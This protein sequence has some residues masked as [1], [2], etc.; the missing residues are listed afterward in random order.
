MVARITVLAAAFLLVWAGT[1]AARVTPS[2][3]ED[4]VVPP[5]VRESSPP[6]RLG[7]PAR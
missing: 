6:S 1:A 7:G 4:E 2:I 5:R 3:H